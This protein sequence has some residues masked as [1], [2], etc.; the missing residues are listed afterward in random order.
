MLLKNALV[1]LFGLE[2]DLLQQESQNF[3]RSVR[4]VAGPG[5]VATD[6]SSSRD[7]GLPQSPSLPIFPSIATSAPKVPLSQCYGIHVYQGL[8]MLR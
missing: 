4:V 1:T 3:G 2:I 5:G 7:A 8:C 6:P